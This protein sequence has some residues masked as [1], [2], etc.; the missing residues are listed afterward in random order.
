MCFFRKKRDEEILRQLRRIACL[1]EEQITREVAHYETL[2][3]EIERLEGAK[4]ATVEVLNKAKIEVPEN[5]KF[6]EIPDFLRKILIDSKEIH[7]VP[8]KG[9]KNSYTIFEVVPE[10]D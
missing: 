5:I 4:V 7:Y 9:K 6:E 8:T 10:E 2:R 1:G 3:R